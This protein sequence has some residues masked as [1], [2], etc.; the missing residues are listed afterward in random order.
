M[1][2]SL[3]L[4]ISNADTVHLNKHSWHS[5]RRMKYISLMYQDPVSIR[6][7]ASFQDDLLEIFWTWEL[8]LNSA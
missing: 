6:N 2:Y 1:M 8:V 5:N 4:N 3:W 7:T